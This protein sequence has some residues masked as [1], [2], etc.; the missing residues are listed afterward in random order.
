MMKVAGLKVFPLEIEQVLCAYPGVKDCVVVP[1]P[2]NETIN[3][4][5]AVIALEP[6]SK[7]FT[8]HGLRR[9]A[10]TRLSAYKMPRVIEVRDALP[11]S[12]TGKVQR[13]ALAQS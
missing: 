7:G 3:R 10:R 2:V 13:R 9:F 11:T 6:D 4:L 1:L 5:R 8:V 12:A